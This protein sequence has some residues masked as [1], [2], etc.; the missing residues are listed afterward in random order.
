MKARLNRNL[1]IIDLLVVLFII[2]TGLLPSSILRAVL[3]L[4]FLFFFPGYTLL[5]AI[6]PR[7]EAD[8]TIERIALSFGVSFIVVALAGLFL[9]FTPW[10]IRLYPLLIVLAVVTIVSS[11]VAWFRHR[12]LAEP[13]PEVSV[14]SRRLFRWRGAGAMEKILTSALAVFVVATIGVLVY[15]VF[16]PRV[17]ESFTEFYIQGSKGAALDFP[18]LLRTGEEASVTAVVQN[19]EK[20]SANYYL[21]V[22]VNGVSQRMLGPFV[23]NN[24]E[25]W[26]GGVIFGVNKPGNGQ[27]VE[28]I[29]YKDDKP[30]NRLYLLVDVYY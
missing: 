9:N 20:E 6:L 18:V 15:V 7:R 10:G 27:K 29:L 26:Q 28:F 11:L 17:N 4:P 1:L 30:Y 24:G 22:S 21:E 8:D 23:L 2:I 3:G 25:K 13:E 5:A 19:H 16:V 12:R 14:A